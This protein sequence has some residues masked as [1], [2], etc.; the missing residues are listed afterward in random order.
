MQNIVIYSNGKQCKIY[1]HYHYFLNGFFTL[2][3][4][5]VKNNRFND[6]D[7]DIFIVP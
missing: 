1:I 5:S 3:L 2:Q 7:I 6:F 4:N